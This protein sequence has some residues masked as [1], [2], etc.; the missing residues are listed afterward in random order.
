MVFNPGLVD[1]PSLDGLGQIGG[2]LGIVDNGALTSLT[3]LEGVA[4]VGD[5]LIVQR[6]D[7][8]VSVSGLKGLKS[9]TGS[10]R[11]TITTP[12]SIFWL[13]SLASVSG[14]VSIGYNAALASL[15]GL[16]SLTAVGGD[17]TIGEDTIEWNALCNST[18]DNP[19]LGSLAGMNPKTIG[20]SLRVRCQTGLVDIDA[21]HATGFIGGDIEIAL[22][23]ALG[24]MGL[25]GSA[26]DLTSMGDASALRVLA[27]KGGPLTQADYSEI[28]VKVVTGDA[29]LFEFEAAECL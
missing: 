8:L 23:P 29:P 3:G 25:G 26:G 14:S 4:A 1:I 9:V 24:L 16:G 17:I 19:N 7:A 22:N 21:F 2:R 10:P 15:A 18:E 28:L 20:G 27:C 11:S 12:W 13:E 5:W 6:N